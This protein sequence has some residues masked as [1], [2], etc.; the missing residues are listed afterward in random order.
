MKKH[1]PFHRVLVG[2]A[3]GFSLA[4]LAGCS[5][6]KDKNLSLSG[7]V[8]YK[9]TPVTGGTLSLA[10]TDGKTPPVKISINGDGNYNIVPPA[11]GNLKV[12]IET[13]SIRAFNA[14]GTPSRKIKGPDGKERIEELPTANQQKYVR[15][16]PKYARPETTD[17]TVDIHA[18]KNE[19]NFELTD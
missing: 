1:S 11:L 12:V 13:E 14:G 4:L 3:L 8:S 5:S 9:G 18:G 15:I 7:K 2:S 6:S 19:K 16:P 17:L 10:P